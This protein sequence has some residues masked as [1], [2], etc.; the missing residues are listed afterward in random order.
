MIILR[1]EGKDANNID[2]DMTAYN[3]W[4]SLNDEGFDVTVSGEEVEET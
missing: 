4:E 1:I 2:A 3:L